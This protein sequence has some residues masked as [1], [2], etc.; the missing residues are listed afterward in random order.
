MMPGKD[1]PQV[2]KTMVNDVVRLGAMHGKEDGLGAPSPRLR[3]RMRHVRRRDVTTHL[4]RIILRLRRGGTTATMRRNESFVRALGTAP[5]KH[6]SILCTL[7]AP[8]YHYNYNITKSNQII[9][10]TNSTTGCDNIE[11]EAKLTTY[12]KTTDATNYTSYTTIDGLD[13]TI[14]ASTWITTE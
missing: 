6:G 14:L 1:R 10:Y 11:G 3:E 9:T 13:G 7:R 2:N 4:Q 5:G 8:G 12:D